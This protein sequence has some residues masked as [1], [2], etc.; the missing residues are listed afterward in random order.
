MIFIM[1]MILGILTVLF[2][3]A[4]STDPLNPRLGPFELTRSQALIH[5][6][7]HEAFDPFSALHGTYTDQAHCD[8]TQNTLWV[9]EGG[10]NGDCIRYY[11]YGLQE[12]SN[13]VALIYFNGDVILRNRKDE[14]FVVA[15]YRTITPYALQYD[16]T[17]WSLQAQAPAILIARPGLYGSSGDHNMRRYPLEITRMDEALNQLKQRYGIEKFILV[18]QSGGGHIVASLLN[19]RQ[20]IQAVFIASGL[21]SVAKTLT[22]PANI[23]RIRGALLPD[24]AGYYDPINEVGKIAHDHPADIFILSDVKDRAVPFATQLDYVKALRKAGLKPYHIITTGEGRQ[25]HLLH[26]KAR[27]AAVMYLR[28]HPPREIIQVLADQRGKPKP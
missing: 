21:L 22:Y 18:G 10:K 15:S 19:R 5:N 23:P 3:V 26:R 9:T 6:E 25:H 4:A 7:P 14:R 1:R 16:M 13:P 20:D 11:P 17:E 2:P 27:L 12:K 8:S 28:Q 24:P